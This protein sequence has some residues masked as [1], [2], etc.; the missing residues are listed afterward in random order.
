MLGPFTTT[1]ISLWWRKLFTSLEFSFCFGFHTGSS[2]TTFISCNV[3][4]ASVREVGW[5]VGWLVVC[6]YLVIVVCQI[7]CFK[8]RSRISI[9]NIL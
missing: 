7:S 9:R 3:K 5:L 6:G 1:S 8:V 2:V 4:G